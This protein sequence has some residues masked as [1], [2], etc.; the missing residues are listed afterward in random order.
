LKFV[1]YFI[2]KRGHYVLLYNDF[3]YKSINIFLVKS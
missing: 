3:N 2:E 1:F